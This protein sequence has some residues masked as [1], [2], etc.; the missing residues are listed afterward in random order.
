MIK[1]A[2]V[3]HRYRNKLVLDLA[4]WECAQGEHW[5][6]LGNS[7]SGKTT[8]LHILAGLLRPTE[9]DVCVGGKTL[10]QLSEGERDQFRGQK[11]GMIFQQLHLI[12]TL[13]VKENLLLAQ[14]MADVSQDKIRVKNVL[15]VLDIQD[16][17]NAYPDELSFGQQQR[18]AIARAVINHPEV[19]LADEPTSGLDDVHT[20]QVIDLLMK[21]A[22]EHQ[23]TLV[24][25]TH[26]QRVKAQIQ[27]QLHLVVA[28]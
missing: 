12:S 20:Q 17:S 3:Q 8:L 1:L 25:A 22:S 11:I 2:A 26:D 15:K 6:V 10:Y 13:T 5:L 18:V 19:I 24:I 27:Q 28:D 14:Y 23:A 7:G 16:K 9:G 4:E 21:Q